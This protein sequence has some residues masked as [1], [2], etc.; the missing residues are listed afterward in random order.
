MASLDKVRIY[1]HL[2][3]RLKATPAADA[4]RRRHISEEA[5]VVWR[6][7]TPQEKEQANELVRQSAISPRP[8][9][10]STTRPARVRGLAGGAGQPGGAERGAAGRGRRTRSGQIP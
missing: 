9:E 8:I 2:L 1:V 10:T 4:A 3:G 5:D 7:L 6:Q